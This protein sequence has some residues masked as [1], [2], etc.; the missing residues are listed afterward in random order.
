MRFTSNASSTRWYTGVSHAPPPAT[1]RHVL[2]QVTWTI[3][4]TINA[5]DRRV[6]PCMTRKASTYAAYAR[7]ASARSYRAIDRRS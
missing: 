6:D 1:H 2:W 5:S 3:S 7:S 4:S